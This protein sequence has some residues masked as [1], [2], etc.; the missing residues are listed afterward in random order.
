[1]TKI[2]ELH[3]KWAKD[4]EYQQ[5]YDELDTEFELARVL[6]DARVAAGLTQ[7][8][9]AERMKTSQAAIARMEGGKVKPSAGSLERYAK[10]IGSRLHIS[11]EPLNPI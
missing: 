5:A 11:F 1:M 10:A 7:A 9:V 3:Q 6:I 2:N 8:Q 4:P